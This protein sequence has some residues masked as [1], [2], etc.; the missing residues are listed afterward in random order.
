MSKLHF[1]K[2][3]QIYLPDS[4]A[5][6][7]SSDSLVE[8]VAKSLVVFLEGMG[9]AEMWEMTRSIRKSDILVEMLIVECGFVHNLFHDFLS[10]KFGF[11]PS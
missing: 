5:T 8:V 2:R 10:R 3:F 7:P 4:A 1:Y 9:R 11:L 6:P